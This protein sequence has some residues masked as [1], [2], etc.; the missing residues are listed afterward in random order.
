MALGAF[1][2]HE[3]T[4]PK[5]LALFFSVIYSHRLVSCTDL[6]DHLVLYSTNHTPHKHTQASKRG[7]LSWQWNWQN[8]RI[9]SPPYPTVQPCSL[10]RGLIFGIYFH[11][12]FGTYSSLTVWIIPALCTT[13]HFTACIIPVLCTTSHFTTSHFTKSSLSSLPSHHHVP[14]KRDVVH[15]AGIIRKRNSKRNFERNSK[16]DTFSALGCT[17]FIFCRLKRILILQ[18][19]SGRPKAK[20]GMHKTK[21]G[22]GNCGCGWRQ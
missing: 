18:T 14:V 2:T 7:Y 1:E 17:H 19:Y 5:D 13:S 12:Y 22:H 20:F 6:R 21:A 10:L 15:S 9:V 11:N 3:L 8:W 16:V 4:N